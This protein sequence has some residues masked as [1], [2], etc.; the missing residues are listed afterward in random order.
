MLAKINNEITRESNDYS[1]W[2]NQKQVISVVT[3]HDN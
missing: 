1:F 2:N 3:K